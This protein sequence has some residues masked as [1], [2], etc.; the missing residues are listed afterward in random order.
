MG[1]LAKVTCDWIFLLLYVLD[2]RFVNKIGF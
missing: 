2:F 1:L